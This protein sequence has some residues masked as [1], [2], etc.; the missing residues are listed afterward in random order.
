[1]TVVCK[2][3]TF[4]RWLRAVW[5]CN[6]YPWDTLSVCLCVCTSGCPC[7]CIRALCFVISLCFYACVFT[8]LRMPVSFPPSPAMRLWYTGGC[9]RM[10]SVCPKRQS[11]QTSALIFRRWKI[12]QVSNDTAQY[13]LSQYICL[14]TKCWASFFYSMQANAAAVWIMT[15]PDML[16]LTRC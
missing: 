11:Q 2:V 9:C 7:T 4:P 8:L 10:Q 12:L 5:Q 1:M 3:I 13:Y 14:I 16:I 15:V 6:C